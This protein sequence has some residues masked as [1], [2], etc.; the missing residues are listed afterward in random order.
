MPACPPPARRDDVYDALTS[1]KRFILITGWSVW[2]D[3]VL[4]RGPGCAEAVPP[5]GKLLLK[6]AEEGVAVLLMVWDDASNNLGLTPGLMATHD[7]ET[8]AF[9]KGTAV[10]CVLCPRQ[11]GEEDSWMQVGLCVC[12]CKKGWAWGLVAFAVSP[13]HCGL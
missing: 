10:K 2:V 1:A 3:T 11:G 5:L 7:N 13:H 4:K 12:A 8:F 6:K 9:F